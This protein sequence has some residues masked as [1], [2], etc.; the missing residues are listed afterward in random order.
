VRAWACVSGRTRARVHVEPSSWF[1]C[2]SVWVG[3]WV[4]G[5]MAACACGCLCICVR[6]FAHVHVCVYDIDMCTVLISP[7]LDA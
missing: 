4:D 6:A 1:V 3:G 2:L 7:F 5:W